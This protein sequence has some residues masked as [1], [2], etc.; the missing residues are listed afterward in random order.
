[1]SWPVD[2]FAVPVIAENAEVVIQEL[3][4][5]RVAATA[6]LDGV[7]RVETG[8]DCDVDRD[9]RGVIDSCVVSPAGASPVGPISI[10][11]YAKAVLYN[12]LGYYSAARVAAERACE[13]DDFMLLEGALAEL[14]EASIRS[15]RRRCALAAARRLD[16]RARRD[17]SAWA[18]GLAARARALVSGDDCAEDSYLDAIERLA[19]AGAPV[20][21]ARAR[22]LYGEW[23][24]RR[25]RRVDAREQLTLAHRVF[26][27]VGIGGFADRA[28]RELLATSKTARKRTDDTRLDLTPQEAQ[29]AELAALGRT[30]PEIAEHL[31]ISS[32][33]VEWHLGKI[34]R[35]LD[36]RSR[37]ELNA[38]FSERACFAAP[39]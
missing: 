36:L 29:I 35:K 21:V 20:A 24:R 30:N 28:C 15:G 5:P 31:F 1:L 16:A 27:E 37:R 3:N 39:E 4:A 25:A 38:V 17:A 33:T 2:P 6:L 18:I 12:G 22:L 32:R 8:P 26:T 10:D 11:E 14:V 23:L 19:V 9:G 34:F 13:H 7:S